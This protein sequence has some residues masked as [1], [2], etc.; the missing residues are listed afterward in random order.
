V[1]GGVAG[2]KNFLMVSVIVLVG[3]GVSGDLS[4][5]YGEPER[6][7]FPVFGRKGI[8]VPLIVPSMPSLTN[9]AADAHKRNEAKRKSIAALFQQYN[10]KLDDAQAYDYAVLIIEASDKFK[11]DPFVIAAM[12][13]NESSA[14]HDA[15]SKQGD[16]GLMQVRWR[17]HRQKITQKYPHID[18]AQDILNPK[19]NVL[20]GTEIF[21]NYH[22]TA[23]EDIKNALMSYTAGNKR[24]TEKI[25]AV[26]GQL[27]KA[28]LKRL[29]N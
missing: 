14:K 11:Q 29:E 27:E 12:V 2:M 21:S 16:Y 8:S 13:V 7:D 1:S 28:Y 5:A 19:D 6:Y 3:I 20:V 18:K 17:V 25:F 10:K 9:F 22:A 24:V 26:R 15:V 4:K 23:K